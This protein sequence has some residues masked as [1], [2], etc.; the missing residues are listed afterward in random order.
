MRSCAATATG[1]FSVVAAPADEN[2]TAATR[3]QTRNRTAATRPI[4]ERD[5]PRS[6]VTSML[7]ELLRW[8]G[9][10]RAEDPWL[11]APA[12]R[13]VCLFGIRAA[14]QWAVLLHSAAAARR[15]AR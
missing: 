6:N 10:L 9:C 4:Q 11:C 8:P 7:G 5:R 15:F 13:R 3:R 2:P 1:P 14:F 12:S